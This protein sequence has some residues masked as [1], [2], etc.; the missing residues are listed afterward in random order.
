M[1]VAIDEADFRRAPLGACVAGRSYLYFHPRASL[2][3]FALWG[4]PDAEELRALERLLLMELEPGFP[5]HVSLV[6]ASRLDAV[7]PTAF[8]E[9]ARYVRAHAERLG[10][11]V[12][13]LAIVRPSGLPG[14]TVAGF[15]HVADAPYPVEIAGDALAALS[16]LGERDDGFLDALGAL[17]AEASG[18]PAWLVALRRLLDAEPGAVALEGAAKTLALSARSLQRRLREA[19]TTFQSEV[20][21]ARVRV[22]ARLLRESNAPLGTIA[23]EVGCATQQHFSALFR[24]V[25]GETPSA[26]RARVRGEG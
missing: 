10:E 8:A 14:A 17:I 13:R 26:F 4:A 25:M 3:G 11:Q 20:A 16:W 15:F 21:N 5:L 7:S 1:R 12:E 19:G 2:C 6:D 18:A 23:L 9:L 22:A 24:R